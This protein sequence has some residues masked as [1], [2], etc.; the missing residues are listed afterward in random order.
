[1]R[2]L[3]ASVSDELSRRSRGKSYGYERPITPNLEILAR[4]GV[5][6]DR[7]RAAAPWTLASHATLFTGLWP[8]ELGSR[9][10]HPMRDDVPTLAEYA[11]VRPG[12]MLR[13]ASSGVPMRD[14][15]GG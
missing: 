11:S 5:R 1:M 6:F 7:A 8:H 3:R 4:G 12:P 9:W 2:G 14:P 13:P 10:M 15:R